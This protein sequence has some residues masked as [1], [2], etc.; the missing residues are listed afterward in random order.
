MGIFLALCAVALWAVT[1]VLAKPGLA[2]MDSVSYGFMRP[3]VASLMVLPYVVL[4]GGFAIG[5]VPVLCLAVLGGIVDMFIGISLFMYAV[6][7]ISVHKAGPLSN[8]APFWGV[9]AATVWL[10][11]LPRVTTYVAALLVVLGSYVLATDGR[12][13]AGR[14]GTDLRGLL[15]ALGAGFCWGIADT[16]IA[17]YCLTHG[18]SRATAHFVYMVAAATCWGIVALLRGRFRREFFPW[19][20]V[21]IALASAVSGMVGGMLLWLMALDLSPASML[22]PTRGALTA[23]VFVLSVVFLRER[24]TRRSGI[25]VGLVG[26][27][28]AVVAVFG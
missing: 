27:G 16:A 7:H 22:A 9:V 10:R 13:V 25:G 14:D 8:T 3:V 5:S 21:R 24:P 1:L 19:D 17:K 12:R 18:M 23:F 4:T 11:E 6:K 15:A 20:G 2:R 26:A 28:I